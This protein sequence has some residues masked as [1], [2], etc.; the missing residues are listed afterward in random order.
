MEDAASVLD[1]VNDWPSRKGHDIGLGPFGRGGYVRG[2]L[3]RGIGLG[4]FGEGGYERALGRAFILKA[5]EFKT[6][7]SLYNQQG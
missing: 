3:G 2:R 5:K 6:I 4:P 1:T 7:R